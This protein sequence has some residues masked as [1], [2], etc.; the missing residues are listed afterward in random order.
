M[1]SQADSYLS[2]HSFVLSF[3]AGV[4]RQSYIFKVRTHMVICSA[5]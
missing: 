2:R 5:G 3:S 4:S 1:V